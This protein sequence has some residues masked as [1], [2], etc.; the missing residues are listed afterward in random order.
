MH[1]REEVLV[2][3]LAC[4]QDERRETNVAIP[5]V[6]G[7][8]LSHVAEVVSVAADRDERVATAGELVC[9]PLGHVR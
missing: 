3:G 2:R 8:G 4:K 9:A 5:A 7:Q 1:R 6:L